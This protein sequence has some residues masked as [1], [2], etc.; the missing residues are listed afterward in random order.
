MRIWVREKG[1]VHEK[2]SLVHAG[3]MLATYGFMLATCWTLLATCWTLLATRE[4]FRKLRRKQGQRLPWQL[5]GIHVGLRLTNQSVEDGADQS[6]PDHAVRGIHV[7]LR[8]TNQSA[9][10]MRAS[11]D[12][13]VRY[14]GRKQLDLL[15]EENTGRIKGYNQGIV[16][17][18]LDLWGWKS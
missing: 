14:M 16:Q 5:R 3:H 6:E 10:T 4:N 2:S 8:L 17:Y 11:D 15:G 18:I 1:H 13:I 12:V 7:G 9:S